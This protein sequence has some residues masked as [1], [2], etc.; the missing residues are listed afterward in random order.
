[1]RHTLKTRHRGG[2]VRNSGMQDLVAESIDNNRHKQQVDLDDIGYIVCK[3]QVAE[4]S[5]L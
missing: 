4:A 1:M 5:V 2:V 3:W